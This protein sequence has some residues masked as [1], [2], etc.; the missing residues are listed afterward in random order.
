VRTIASNH[1][2]CPYDFRT[3]GIGPALRDQIIGIVI[4]QIA[5]KETILNS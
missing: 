4:C 1:V 5:S 2:L 3:S